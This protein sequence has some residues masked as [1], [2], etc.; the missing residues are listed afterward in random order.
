MGDL[1]GLGSARIIDSVEDVP[2]WLDELVLKCIRKVRE[3]RYQSIDTVFG[4]IKALS[5]RKGSGSIE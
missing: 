4:E 3:D 2:E 1:D 5:K